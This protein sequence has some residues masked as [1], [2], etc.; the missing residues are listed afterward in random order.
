MIGG[1]GNVAPSF[2]D[3]DPIGQ[4]SPEIDDPPTGHIYGTGSPQITTLQ[5]VCT[6]RVY[7]RPVPLVG[8]ALDAPTIR[9]LDPHT[10]HTAAP[11]LLA[12]PLTAPWSSAKMIWRWKIT[13]MTRVG[14]RISIVPAHRRGISFA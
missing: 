4:P 9:E 13:K 5:E 8:E 6:E 3:R 1:M 12:H 11:G 10:R 7:D 2:R 14:T